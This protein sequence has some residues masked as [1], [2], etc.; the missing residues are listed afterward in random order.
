ML[1]V[2][3]QNLLMGMAN[4]LSVTFFFSQIHHKQAPSLESYIWSQ[5]L[6]HANGG[7]Q[8]Q[9]F[10][11]PFTHHEP[12]E[13]WGEGG[14]PVRLDVG[15]EENLWGACHWVHSSSSA[16]SCEDAPGLQYQFHSI[17]SVIGWNKLTSCTK[18]A[19][20]PQLVC[21]TAAPDLG[22]RQTHAQTTTHSKLLTRKK[23][24]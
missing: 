1:W 22:Y 10:S 11:G 24:C 19:T 3:Y 23:K 8:A 13:L 6:R 17:T 9:A 5:R 12:P 4:R 14:P 18:L 21:S 15:T 7:R 16:S 2:F 20:G